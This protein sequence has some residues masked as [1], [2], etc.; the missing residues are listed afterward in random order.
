MLKKL[1]TRLANRFYREY[2]QTETISLAALGSSAPLSSFGYA[3]I[4]AP[5]TVPTEA[6]PELISTTGWG[7]LVRMADTTPPSYRF[8]VM[9]AT[10]GSRTLK[11][12]WHWH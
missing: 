12:R 4:T 5:N 7:F 6:W 1:L 8:I 3:L 11:I 10:S 9:G 2:D